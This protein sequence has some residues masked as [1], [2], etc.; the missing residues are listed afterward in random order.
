MR[1]NVVLSAE[2]HSASVDHLLQHYNHNRMQE[3][4]CFALWRPSSGNGRFTAIVDEVLLPETGERRLHGNASFQPHYMVRAIRTARRKNTGLAFMHSHPGNGWQNMSDADI[5]AERD[6]LAYPAGSTG[7]P[8][9]GMTVGGDGYWSSRFWERDGDKMRRRWCSKTRVVAPGSYQIYHNDN[10]EPPPLRKEVLKR[11]F[12]TWGTQSQSTI[13]RLRV[14][15]VGLG[16]VGCVIAEATARLGVTHVTL[17]DPDKVEEHNLDRLIYGTER[18]IGR[19]KV[20]LASEAM[21]RN[22]TADRIHIDV[23]PNSIREIGAYKAALDCDIIFSCVDRPVPRDILNYVAN[24][25]FIPVID[26]GVAVETDVVNETLF[27]AHWRAH[28]ITPYH[29]CMQCNGQYTSSDVIME[30]DG[31]LD[32]PSYVTNLPTTDRNRNLNVFPFALNVASME[33]NLMLRYI[34]AQ[35]WWPIIQQQHYQFVTAHLQ[36]VMEE[37][38]PYCSFRMHRARGD[39][40]L[41]FYLLDSSD[42]PD[43]PRQISMRR[44]FV[45]LLDRVFSRF[46][47]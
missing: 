43:P 28:L 4:L 25:H 35:P 36:T 23:F 33:V 9:V 10:L 21:R 34:L 24:A 31:S 29:Q 13:S 47:P 19:L 41:P 37:C 40:A 18:D 44:K 16:S 7:L 5:K 46:R 26:G 42:Q 38:L 6:I 3:D 1:F 12:D 30:L 8:L 45:S 20:E 2:A 14:G 15:I 32:D 22:S 27:A 39:T 11:T 17:I